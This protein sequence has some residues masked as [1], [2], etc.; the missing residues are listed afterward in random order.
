MIRSSDTGKGTSAQQVDTLPVGRVR[1][2]KVD[3]LVADTLAADK[4]E[5][6]EPEQRTSRTRNH[7]AESGI[8]SCHIPFA[9]MLARRIKR[10]AVKELVSSVANS[11]D[12]FKVSRH[13]V[14]IDP[15][16]LTATHEIG[17][18]RIGLLGKP[19]QRRAGETAYR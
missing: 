10:K 3:T 9:R 1:I 19:P 7:A 17:G 2:D 4:A 6:V 8:R 18:S 13:S 11:R 16:E 5:R 14:I 12:V 15:E